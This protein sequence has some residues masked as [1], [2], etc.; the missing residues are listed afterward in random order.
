M[1]IIQIF[2][3]KNQILAQMMNLKAAQKKQIK[4]SLE[5]IDDDPL[6][7]ESSSLPIS[8]PLKYFGYD[9]FTRDP[10]LF[11]LVLLEL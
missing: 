6:A 4:K 10:S 8:A 3:S 11:Q 5:I 2:C 9:I 1:K 7:I